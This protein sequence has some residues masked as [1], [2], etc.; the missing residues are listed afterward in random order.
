MAKDYS[1]DLFGQPSLYGNVK[2][3]LKYIFQ[4]RKRGQMKI[5]DY[6]CCYQDMEVM[7]I[8]MFIKK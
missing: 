6:C 2:G 4:N 8:L 1:F 3:N 7:L 5:Q